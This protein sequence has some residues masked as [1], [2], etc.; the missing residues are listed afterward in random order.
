MNS[1]QSIFAMKYPF[2]LALPSLLSAG[3]SSGGTSP[4]HSSTGLGAGPNDGGGA[5]AEREAATAILPGCTAVQVIDAS[6]LAGYVPAC[7]QGYAH[8][9]VCCHGG[10]TEPTVCEECTGSHP[11][12]VCGS[13]S[14]SFPDPTTCCSLD[15]GAACVEVSVPPDAGYPFGGGCSYYCGPGGY[16]PG[17]LADAGFPACPGAGINTPV[18]GPCAYCC[19]SSPDTFLPSGYLTTCPI[20]ACSCPESAPCVCGPQCSACPVG[21]HVPLGGQVDLCCRTSDAGATDCFSMANSITSN[22][23]SANP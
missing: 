16:P 21:W 9:S 3:C 4:G 20:S 14:L 2:V 1:H 22:P 15:D 11:F 12:S 23:R 5:D 7:E 17:E 13:S 10:P 6:S 18:D 8:P 19:S